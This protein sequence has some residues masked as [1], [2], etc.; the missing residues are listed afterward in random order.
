MQQ[1]LTHLRRK[2]ESSR[3]E[4]FRRIMLQ[5]KLCLKTVFDG[6]SKIRFCGIRKW[7]VGYLTW[8]AAFISQSR[9]CWRPY[10]GWYWWW[11][12]CRWWWIMDWS[13]PFVRSWRESLVWLCVFRVRVAVGFWRQVA[14]SMAPD[15]IS[16]RWWLTISAYL[17]RVNTRPAGWVGLAFGP[18]PDPTT[19]F[20]F[21]A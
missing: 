9:G 18:M 4:K 15:F 20:V 13:G 7:Q 5:M 11:F 14:E 8:G 6:K 1:P 17:T 3:R 12:F 19:S 10:D 21:I 16:W 2:P